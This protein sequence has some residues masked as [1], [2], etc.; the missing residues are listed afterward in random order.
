VAEDTVRKYLNERDIAI[1]CKSCLTTLSEHSGPEPLEISKLYDLMG[2]TA[3]NL[4]LVMPVIL[5]DYLLPHKLVKIDNKRVQITANG[6]MISKRISEVGL[7]WKDMLKII[8]DKTDESVPKFESYLGELLSELNNIFRPRLFFNIL[9]DNQGN[10]E[11]VLRNSGRSASYNITCSFDPDLPYY[12]NMTL[13]KLKLFK[14]LPFLERN[15]EI[16]FFFNYLP[17]VLNDESIPK[18]TKVTVHYLDSSNRSYV[19][20]YIVDLEKHSEI[21]AA[22]T[23]SKTVKAD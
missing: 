12:G 19:D 11:V 14:A 18:V 1:L 9:P 3:F 23:E 5:E 20:D 2:L 4:E 15:Q 16:K 8:T 17:S 22:K 7:S 13:G 10:L 21:L 6:I